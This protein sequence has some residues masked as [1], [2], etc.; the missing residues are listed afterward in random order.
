MYNKLPILMVIIILATTLS[1]TLAAQTP[2]AEQ[3]GSTAIHKDGRT[4]GT[5]L[6]ASGASI[7]AAGMVGYVFAAVFL[8]SALHA[9][10]T[11]DPDRPTMSPGIELLAAGMAGGVSTL[12]SM[13]GVPLLVVGIIK[14]ARW[15]KSLEK[16][17]VSIGFSQGPLEGRSG[18]L[19]LSW[20]F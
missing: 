3:A 2:Q 15:K 12:V 13:V 9:S 16:P 11:A 7:V 19:A 8:V 14:R 6:I 10:A 5:G 1:G 20:R 4:H 17:L 18:M